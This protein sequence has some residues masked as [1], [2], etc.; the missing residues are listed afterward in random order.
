MI[1][2]FWVFVSHASVPTTAILYRAGL[3][4]VYWIARSPSRSSQ[5]SLSFSKAQG[6]SFTAIS[7]SLPVPSASSQLGA[8]TQEVSTTIS[9]ISD[10]S[11]YATQHHHAIYLRSDHSTSPHITP[12]Q[13]NSS[14]AAHIY[15]FETQSPPSPSAKILRIDQ[16]RHE[17]PTPQM[18]NSTSRTNH[19]SPP[20]KVE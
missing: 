15:N 6:T 18:Q 8:L 4:L 1:R 11:L 7:R 17:G 10:E 13:L 12:Q 14:R 3:V 16:T 2:E 20:S 9:P 5:H 19:G